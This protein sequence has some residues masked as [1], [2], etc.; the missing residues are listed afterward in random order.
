V[1]Q[2]VDGIAYLVEHFLPSSASRQSIAELLVEHVAMTALSLAIAVAIG[3]P[4]GIVIARRA[5]WR[6]PILSVFGAIYTIPSLAMLVLLIT[7]FGIGKTPAIIALV[8]YAQLVIVRNTLVGLT[9][10]DAAVVESARGIGMSS[11]QRL[12]RVELPLALPMILAGVRVAALS[13]IGIGAIAAFIN[14]G[15]LGVLLF[16]GILSGNQP[17]IVAGSIAISALALCTSSLLRWLERRAAAATG[18]AEP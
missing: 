5:R 9:G 16:T 13:I 10:I 2:I 6:G 15:G 3:V 14:A 18:L 12:L 4:V 1:T 11:L 8:V 7:V 17:M